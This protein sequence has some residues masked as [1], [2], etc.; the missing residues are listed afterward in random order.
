MC[1]HVSPKVAEWAASVF[2]MR[3]PRPLPLGFRQGFGSLAG[4]SDGVLS[5]SIGPNLTLRVVMGVTV[6]TDSHL[7]GATS[8]D[9]YA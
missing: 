8:T 4:L 9:A 2:A 6:V 1:R 7:L 3:A 5:I